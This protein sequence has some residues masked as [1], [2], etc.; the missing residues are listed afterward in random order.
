MRIVLVDPRGDSRPYDHG[1][2]AALAAR[3]HDVTLATCRFH[4]GALPP[5]PGVAV[6]ER[7]YRLAD[8]LPDRALS[9][10]V[11]ADRRELPT[12]IEGWSRAP[13]GFVVLALARLG[14][15]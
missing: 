3:G 14:L 9:C 11:D 6:R 8:R 5:A 10:L 7:F 2:G 13:R 4:H 1:L 15:G 12:G